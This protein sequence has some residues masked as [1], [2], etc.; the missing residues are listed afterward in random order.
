VIGLTLA[1]MLVIVKYAIDLPLRSVAA[2][3][4]RPLM[5]TA[6]TSG[7]CLT[8][9]ALLPELPGFAL[10]MLTLTLLVSSTCI[11]VF[12]NQERVLGFNGA[13]ALHRPHK[14]EG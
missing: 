1:I 2:V 13:L 12:F 4:L 3:H 11:F 9:K 8:A 5:M 6:A 7:L 10:L 14:G